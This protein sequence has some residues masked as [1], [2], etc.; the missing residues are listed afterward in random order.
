MF[1]SRVF[2][3]SFSVSHK[4]QLTSTSSQLSK[5]LTTVL[6]TPG[7]GNFNV[8]S[9]ALFNKY[10]DLPGVKS[11]LAEADESLPIDITQ[12][13]RDLSVVKE[14]SNL[15]KASPL[16]KTSIQQPLLILTSKITN[17]ILKELHGVDLFNLPPQS[18]LKPDFMIGHSL[19]E[20]SSLVLQD[21]LCFE[22]GLKL[23]HKRGKLMEEIISKLTQSGSSNNVDD[24]AYTMMVLMFQSSIYQNLLKEMKKLSVLE[25][26]NTVGISNINNFQQIVISGKKYIISQKI[27][28]LK[29]NLAKNHVWKGRIRPI[30]LNVKVPFHHPILRPIQNELSDL[31]D[32]YLDLDEE[33]VVPVI[34]N[35]NGEI[36]TSLKG[37]VANIVEVTSKP[38]LFVNCL[39]KSLS[40]TI[41]KDSNDKQ[42]K[43]RF[44][45]FGPGNVTHGIISKFINDYKIVR[46]L[47]IHDRIE[48]LSLD[49]EA[50]IE[51]V[52]KLYK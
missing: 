16:Q 12:Y 17:E 36:T 50:N 27:E 10:R 1:A 22:N 25:D 43:I 8:D 30:D 34:S 4:S 7:Q 26:E 40:E 46:K 42:S 39:E 15:G 28:E 32:E 35:L 48:N 24:E 49:N 19:G 45:N 20:I 11:L 18:E 31:F 52:S 14:I 38:V 47:D 44:I 51:Q 2:Q 21:H 23:A 9:L 33:L 37:Q 6:V 3:R 29:I 41:L 13:I 5:S